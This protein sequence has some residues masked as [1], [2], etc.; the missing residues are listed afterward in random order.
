MNKRNRIIANVHRKVIEIICLVFAR[1]AFVNVNFLLAKQG[2]LRGLKIV[3]LSD[4]RIHYDP[5]VI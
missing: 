3:A 1:F 2:I 5:F 4:V